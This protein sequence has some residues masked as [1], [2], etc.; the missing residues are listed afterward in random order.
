M[1]MD[2][3]FPETR[4]VPEVL[5]EVKNLARRIGPS[6]EISL[7]ASG[8]PTYTD[9]K[10]PEIVRYLKTAEAVLKTQVKVKGE[11]GASDARYWAKDQI[12]IIV[13]KPMGGGIHSSEEWVDVDS[14]LVFYEILLKYL[15]DFSKR[16]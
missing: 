16:T 9:T 12:P 15:S 14:C 11:C 3:R 2:F 10:H 5:I 4:S 6:M 1:K 7:L 8:D 13:T